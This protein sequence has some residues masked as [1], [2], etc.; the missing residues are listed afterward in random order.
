MNKIQQKLIT[1]TMV[2][3]VVIFTACNKS[4]DAPPGPS[5]PNIVANTTIQNLKTYHVTPAVLDNITQDVII[6]GIVVANDQ[7]GNFYKQLFIQDST[8]AIQ[9]L[10]DAS[11]LYASYPVGRRVYVKCKGLTLSDYYGTMQLGVKAT[12]GGV[13]SIQGIP[14]AVISNY[15]IGGSLNNPVVPIPVTLSQLGSALNDR[16]L[17]AL[18][19]LQDYEFISGDTAKSY[20]DTSAYRSTQNRTISQGCGSSSTVIVRT[21]AYSYFTG[22]GLPKGNGSINA[23]YTV[24]KSFTG[25][26]TKQLVIRDTS[27]VQFNNSRCGAPPPGTVVLLN[28][29]FETQNATTGAPYNPIS[30]T[31]W[32][33]I[34]EI[35]TRTYSGKIFS[36][37]KY[38]YLTAFGSGGQVKTWLVTKGINLDNTSIEALSFSNQQDYSSN[39]SSSLKVLISSNYTGTGNPWTAT[40]TDL[41]S[42]ATLCPPSTLNFP[43]YVSSGNI[44]LSSYTGTVYIAFV[45]DGTDPG[46]SSTWELDNIKVLGL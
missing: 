1:A 35:G 2:V 27:D 20:S 23:I 31:G 21:S 40:W 10:V 33:N 11:G 9:L 6:S 34:S 26:A 36:N 7:S 13:T 46:S 14:G 41:T 45:Y 39:G 24:Y 37:N 43:G 25:T 28:E 8:A 42:L 12:V 5:D 30:I 16:Y 22:F 44:D 3:A 32:T 18:I 29:D 15:I 38:A 4:F 17:N 19:Q